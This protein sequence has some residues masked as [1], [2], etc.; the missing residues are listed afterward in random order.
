[1]RTE[2]KVMVLFEITLFFVVVIMATNDMYTG[3]LI[4]LSVLMVVTR[5]ALINAA[6]W[7]ESLDNS[8]ERLWKTVREKSKLRR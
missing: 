5:I 7:V 4:V 3:A 8:T 1:M 2:D 6:I